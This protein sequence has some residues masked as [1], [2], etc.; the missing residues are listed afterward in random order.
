MAWD[1]F[2]AA[3]FP[4]DE[5]R[6][7]ALALNLEMEDDL[8]RH[9]IVRKVGKDVE[10]HAPQRPPRQ[11]C[12]RPHG[13]R[14]STRSS[15]PSTRPCS[16]TP[17]TAGPPCEVFL[18]RTGLLRDSAFQ[19]AIEAFVT[20]RPARPERRRLRPPRGGPTRSPPRR[21]LS[22]TSSRPPIPVDLVQADLFP[23]A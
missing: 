22:R 3:R 14:L 15:T 16:S 12:R 4:A 23:G 21:V 9:K 19:S 8:V 18:K 10:F 7:L 1:A 5:A 17:R 13:G 6:K 2:Q 20:R 11:E